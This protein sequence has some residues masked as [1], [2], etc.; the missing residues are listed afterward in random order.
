MKLSR[1]LALI[2]TV[3][4]LFLAGCERTAEFPENTDTPVG[5]SAPEEKILTNVFAGHPFALP[6]SSGKTIVGEVKPYYDSEA[7]TYTLL[8]GNKEGTAYSLM[9]FDTA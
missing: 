5:T 1:S 9:T 6:E 7:G 4:L 3:P 8:T 2:L